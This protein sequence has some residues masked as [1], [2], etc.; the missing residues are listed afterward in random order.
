MARNETVAGVAPDEMFA[1]LLDPYAYPKWVAGTRRIRG[2]DR[3]WPSVGARF[4][5]TVGVGP[6]STR[7]ST[8]DPGVTTAVRLG[9]RGAL[10]PARRRLRLTTALRRW[11]RPLQD[12]ADGRPN[13]GTRGGSAWGR[14]GRGRACQERAVTVATTPS[15]RVATARVWTI[16]AAE[17]RDL[18]EQLTAVSAL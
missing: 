14:L 15:G 4:H 1:L 12:R 18:L 3:D 17:T 6:F 8:R 7:D 11:R 10:P 9:P 13:R 5:H 16:R 2:V